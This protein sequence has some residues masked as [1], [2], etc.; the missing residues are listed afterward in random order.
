M[1]L[2]PEIIDQLKNVPLFFGLSNKTLAKHLGHSNLITIPAGKV[3]LS[4]GNVNENMYVILSGRLRVTPDR[5]IEEPI[6]MFGSGESVGET[7]ILNSK[8][9]L[10]YFIADTD[11]ELLCIDL[12]TIWSLINDSHHAALNMLNILSR[13]LPMIKRSNPNIEI[14]QG[15]AGLNQ[16]DELTGLYNSQ[17]MLQ[18]FDRQI[19]RSSILHDP[20]ILMMLSID[21]FDHY[22]QLHGLLGGDQALRAITHTILTCLRPGDQ[23]AR[24]YGNVLSVFMPHTTLEEGRNAGQRLL[25]HARQAVI[26]TPGGDALPNVTISIGMTETQTE[27]TLQ[28]LIKQATEALQHAQQSGGNCISS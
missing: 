8:K 9:S 24:Y 20:A 13:P 10:D 11:C 22:N 17:W 2:S 21:Q 16:V 18:T 12:T 6:A 26:A 4:P 15:Y 7:S 27:N 3:L 1:S 19:H 28:H 23:A 14:Q 25:L 5:S